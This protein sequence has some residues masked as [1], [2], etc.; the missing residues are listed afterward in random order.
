[1]TKTDVF[2]AL[3]GGDDIADFHLIPGDNHPIDQ[4]FDQ[5]SLLFEGGGL[6]A[7]VHT[8]AER[9]HRGGEAGGFVETLRLLVELCLLPHQRSLA[10]LQVPAAALVLR[11]RDHAA[12]V[13]FGQTFQLLLQTD[14][15]AAEVF[16]AGLQLLRQPVAGMGTLKCLGDDWGMA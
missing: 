12:Q 7:G 4:Q 5:L 16:T 2:T 1:M 15:A 8:L 9:L 10:L 11:Q 6:Q 13:R 3:A 14:L